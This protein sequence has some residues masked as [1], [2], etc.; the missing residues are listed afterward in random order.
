[1]KTIGSLIYDT[2]KK[3]GIQKI[4]FVGHGQ[5]LVT[6]FDPQTENEIWVGHQFPNYS[7]YGI[8]YKNLILEFCRKVV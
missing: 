5:Y 1:M 6:Y 7:G 3:I 4:K 2:P 8:K